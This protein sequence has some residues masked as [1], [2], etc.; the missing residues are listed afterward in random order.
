VPSLEPEEPAEAATDE[1][2]AEETPETD[3]APDRLDVESVKRRTQSPD[4]CGFGEGP[5]EGADL[6]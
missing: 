1:R 3:Q 4:S 2:I 6:D 5:E